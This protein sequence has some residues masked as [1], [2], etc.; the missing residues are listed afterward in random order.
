[1][2][3]VIY[4]KSCEVITLRDENNYLTEQISNACMLYK[5]LLERK[6]IDTHKVLL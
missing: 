3:V 4:N 2:G 1:M 6:K 5:D